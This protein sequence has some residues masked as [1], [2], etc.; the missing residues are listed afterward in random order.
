[1]TD[2]T[3]YPTHRCFDDVADFFNGLIMFGI[4]ELRRY[5]VVHGVMLAPSDGEPHA[6][7]WVERDGMVIQAGIQRGRRIIFRQRR[8]E[9]LARV[10]IFD[11]TRY[12]ID[13][14]IDLSRRHGGSG[15]WNPDYVPLCGASKKAWRTAASKTRT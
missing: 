9:F 1:M 11:E 7:A 4:E 3:I 13:E 10:K 6:H 8:A 15:P 2:D 14:A 12:T 5:T